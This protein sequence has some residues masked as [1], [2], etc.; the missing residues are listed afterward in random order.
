MRF[1]FVFYTGQPKN[2]F[3]SI[4]ALKSLISTNGKVI[5]IQKI[6]RGIIVTIFKWKNKNQLTFLNFGSVG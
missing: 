4:K 2:S 6:F 1:L 5:L 3:L